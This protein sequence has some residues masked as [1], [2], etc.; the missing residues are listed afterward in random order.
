MALVEQ[1]VQDLK[2]GARMLRRNPVFT[3]VAIATLAIGL[4]ANTAIFS[5]VNAILL[6]PLPYA[7]PSRLFRISGMSYTGEFV[8][9]QRRATS[10]DVAG[11]TQQQVT[12]SGEDEPLRLPAAAVS[13]NLVR[14]LGADAALGRVLAPGDEDAAES[15][16]LIS[17][18]L[19]RNRFGSDP[20][21][22]GRRITVDGV[23]RRVLGVMPAGFDFPA[24]GIE[25]WTPAKIDLSDRIALWSSSLLMIGR[26][27]QA[28]SLEQADAE[29]R[30]LAPGMGALFPWRMPAE[31]GRAAGAAPCTRRW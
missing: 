28:A 7:E 23:T 21:M 26:P 2:Y 22:I 4:G 3:S 13:P 29:I 5:V 11:Y 16:V 15:V 1:G 24:P 19:W 27:R 14:L 6:R 18:Q 10:F 12:L 17:Q 31:Y 8:E 25:L 9:L 30:T 20:R